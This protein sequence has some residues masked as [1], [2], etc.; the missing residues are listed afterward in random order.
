MPRSPSRDLADRYDGNR[1][2]FHRWDGVR[3]AKYAL[4]AVA[5]LV[6]AGWAAYDLAGP[7]PTAGYA[8]THGPLTGVHAAWDGDCAACHVSF[9]AADF[10]RDPS[11]VL[12]TADRWRQL[13]CEK[14][15][16]GPIHHL[17]VADVGFNAACNN[18]HHD[19]NG[20]GNS[21]VR[22]ADSHCTTCHAD[23]P[24]HATGPTA[25]QTSITD[26]AVN[27][28]EFR[29]LTEDAKRT[30][31]FS[32]ALH[33]APGQA[34]TSGGKETL[35]VGRLRQLFGDSAADRYA[36][37]GQTA[38]SPVQLD[39]ASCH[40][41][42]GGRPGPHDP[43]PTA[44]GKVADA[45]ADQPLKSIL[46]VR[47]EGAY[48]LPVNFDAHCKTCHPLRGPQVAADALAGFEVPHR[49]QPTE[50]KG[51]L[52]GEYARRLA[53]DAPKPAPPRVG[54]G[55]RFDPRDDPAAVTFRK[56]AE[57][58]VGLALSVLVRSGCNKCHGE[59]GGGDGN[60][61]SGWEKTPVPAVQDRTV[62]FPH[63]KFNHVSHRGVACA[64]C[65]RMPERP[66][67][68]R[69]NEW[70]PP[71]IAGVGSCKACH[72]PAGK[73]VDVGNG[74]T[75]A[76]LG[77]RHGCTDCHR[78]HNGDRPLQG[79]GAAARDPADPLPADLFRRG[80]R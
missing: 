79:R 62:W 63:A 18:C 36:R 48:Y 58:R 49:K 6:P 40:Q 67:D 20:R 14:C 78:Y 4:A 15:H 2:Y 60:R 52:L 5:L 53:A 54:P 38:D 70:E 28:P 41:L 8:H 75:A 55:G 71:L 22:I 13:T 47:A 26:F 59:A 74:V 51:I 68:G 27:H 73:V 7:R 39:C 34:Y 10:A 24:A 45:L 1:D 77:V 16:A 35:T 21:L 12:R 61:G 31:K 17:N 66:A 19:H 23:L 64:D 46:P 43:P 33:M 76:A 65:H 42:D 56:E 72:A 9:S 50:L 32:H 44:F 29:P 37:S 80:G 30:L 25:Y 3:R 11:S 69:V 57:G